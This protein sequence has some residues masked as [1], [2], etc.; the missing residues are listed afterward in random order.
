[1]RLFLLLA[2]GYIYL[3]ANAHI[4]LYHRFGDTRY[5]TTNT[6]IE[7]LRKH[8]EYFKNNNYQV[9]ALEKIID[10]INN[11]ETIPDNWV[12]L[13]I[14]DAYKSFYENGLPL[15]KEYNYPFTLYTQVAGREYTKSSIM[16]WAQLKEVTQYGKVELHSYAHNHLTWLSE[17]E[18][19]DNTQKAFDLFTQ[20]MGYAPTQFA[21]PYGEYNQKVKEVLKSFGFKAILNQNNGSVNHNS[22]VYDIDRIALVGEVDLKEKFKYESFSVNWVEPQEYPKD[23]ILKS[24]KAKVDP[25]IK[26]VKLYITGH[27]WRDINVNDGIIDVKLNLELKKDRSRVIIGQTYYKIAN[28]ILIKNKEKPH[29]K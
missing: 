16:H 15:F 10:K 23:N 21:Y 2:L 9:V 1:M 25:A 24:V 28:K 29:V 5:P 18:I 17:E 8:F 13:T 12:A 26:S 4:F 7:E 6:S 14:D 3:S 27:G 11:K 22:D 20:N 19:K